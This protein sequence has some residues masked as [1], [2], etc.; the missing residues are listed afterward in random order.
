MK[1]TTENNE[2]QPYENLK[3]IELLEAMTEDMMWTMRCASVCA[4]F[5]SGAYITATIAQIAD[6]ILKRHKDLVNSIP[7]DMQAPIDEVQ[8]L[9]TVEKTIAWGIKQ[10]ILTQHP[11]TKMIAPSEEGWLIGQDWDIRL[12]TDNKLQYN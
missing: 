12:N 4:A 1:T 5:I 11:T 8:H 6:V 2:Q 7:E 9:N 3:A 10:G